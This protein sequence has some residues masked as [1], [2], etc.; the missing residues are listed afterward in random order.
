MISDNWQPLSNDSNLNSND[1]AMAI[2]DQWAS[3]LPE[4]LLQTITTPRLLLIPST[5]STVLP[6][7]KDDGGYHLI[8]YSIKPSDSPDLIGTAQLR[9]AFYIDPRSNQS[10][11]AD[12]AHISLNMNKVHQGNG[13]SLES[14]KAILS[15]IFSHS[16]TPSQSSGKIGNHS[17]LLSKIES[18]TPPLLTPPRDPSPSTSSRRGRSW[19]TVSTYLDDHVS[20]IFQNLSLS[21][22]H[23]SAA[24]DIK[25]NTSSSMDSPNTPLAPFDLFQSPSLHFASPLNSP[26]TTISHP[27]PKDLS[28]R[29]VIAT[30]LEGETDHPTPVAATPMEIPSSPPTTSGTVSAPASGIAGP[31]PWIPQDSG[32]EDSVFFAGMGV[33]EMEAAY[34]STHTSAE[35]VLEKLGF[36]FSGYRFHP[37]A[38]GA[39]EEE[40]D[41]DD[42]DEVCW[43][44]WALW[45]LDREE[46][47]AKWFHQEEEDDE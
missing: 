33:K 23:P 15:T 36:V 29:R 9:L 8:E 26:T 20:P 24:I 38:S 5:P 13:F 30:L 1:N 28:I 47:M 14:L 21:S 42:T 11:L 4:E 12:T 46:F 35:Y 18:Q 32:Y 31:R 17:E 22:S 27:S 44:R 45:E 7:F 43:G 19:D 10:E 40:E 39:S 41:G 3:I 16:S 2:L 37:L 6:K 25:R 34:L